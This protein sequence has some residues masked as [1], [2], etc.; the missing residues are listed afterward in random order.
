MM[1]YIHAGLDLNSVSMYKV[2]TEAGVKDWNGI[3]KGLKLDEGYLDKM[4]TIFT[5]LFRR[6]APTDVVNELLRNWRPTRTWEELARVIENQISFEIA[7][8]TRQLSES[9]R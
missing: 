3:A 2:L 1:L 6:K 5:S 7:Q 4:I 9:G 8:K